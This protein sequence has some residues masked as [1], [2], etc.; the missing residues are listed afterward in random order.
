M[1]MDPQK[2][3]ESSGSRQVKWPVENWDRYQFSAFLGEG[4][5]GR[6]Y[7]AFDSR[8]KRPVA[9]KFLR[10]DALDA[11]DRLLQE[12]QAQARIEHDNVCKIYE[13]GEAAQKPYIAMQYIDGKTL[14]DAYKSLNLEQQIRLVLSIC[15]GVHEAH[16]LGL[17]HRDI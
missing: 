7:K 6:V 17:I 15:Q 5:M 1:A 10:D 8:L 16:R 14:K 4:S 2:P 12:A 3:E 11:A 13:V 9:L